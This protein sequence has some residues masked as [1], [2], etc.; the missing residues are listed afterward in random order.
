MLTTLLEDLRMRLVT[1]AFLF[2]D[3]HAYAA[4]V[5]D[6]LAAVAVALHTA[7]ASGT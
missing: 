4:G 6:A 7:S 3:P 5:E 2:E 1:Q